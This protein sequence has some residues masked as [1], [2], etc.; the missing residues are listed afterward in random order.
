MAFF[1]GLRNALVFAA[2][3]WLAAGVILWACM[4]VL[5]G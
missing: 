4:Q 3:F 5:G 2:A 1:R